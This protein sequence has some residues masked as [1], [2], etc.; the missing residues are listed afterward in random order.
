MAA[1][2]LPA[3]RGRGDALR[4]VL[5]TVLTIVVAFVVLLV[6][7]E[8][9]LRVFGVE[10]FVG[11][12]PTDVW[13]WAFDGD[14][15][16]KNRS[17][18]VT[19]L[20]RTLYDAGLGFVVGMAV[21]IAVAVAFVMWRPVE[22]AFLPIAMA[23]RTVPIVA[24]TPLLARLFDRGILGTIVVVSIVVFFPTLVLV[25]HGLRSASTEK[26]DLMRAYN[27]S[28]AEVLRKV[29]IPSAMPSIFAAAKVAAPG[30]ILGALLAE[31]FIT[32]EGLGY[33]GLLIAR[34]QS[35][36][37]QVWATTFVLIMVSITFYTIIGAIERTVLKRYAPEQVTL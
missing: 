26:I 37:N 35:K 29:R 10:R 23:L 4:S 9:F 12:R 2:T 5:H 18:V 33:E 24:I 13:T 22:Q 1:T 19:G 21:S 14:A 30:A 11:K 17:A 28:P 27:A 3:E 16:G 7:W 20:G 25:S 8:L 6:V 34:T 36:F 15:A 32:G 31:W